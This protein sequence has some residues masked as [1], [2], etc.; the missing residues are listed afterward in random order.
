MLAPDGTCAQCIGTGRTV[1]YKDK[2]NADQSL[3]QNTPVGGGISDYGRSSDGKSCVDNLAN[4]NPNCIEYLNATSCN[5]CDTGFVLVQTGTPTG[6]LRKC[7]KI[8]NVT[9]KANCFVHTLDGKRCFT[10]NANFALNTS[11]G[12][13]GITDP[14]F[15]PAA[16]NAD[17]SNCLRYQKGPDGKDNTSKCL[18]CVNF[19]FQL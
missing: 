8:P 18:K 9:A 4:A 16:T 7:V 6:S 12:C 11:G 15:L 1:N 2:F 5:L 3:V 14:N 13:S 17:N 19:S 10:C